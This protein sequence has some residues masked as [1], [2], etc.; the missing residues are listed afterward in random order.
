MGVIDIKQIESTI[1]DYIYEKKGIAVDVNVF[2][3]VPVGHA[4]TNVVAMVELHKAL[5]V[6]DYIN[7]EKEGDK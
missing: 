7:K 2:K 1:S 6:Y 5:A 4:F 3:N